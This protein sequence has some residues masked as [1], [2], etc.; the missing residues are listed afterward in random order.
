[1]F[2]PLCRHSFPLLKKKESKNESFAEAGD[3]KSFFWTNK[4]IFSSETYRIFL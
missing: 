2:Y 4:D 3:N 1:V